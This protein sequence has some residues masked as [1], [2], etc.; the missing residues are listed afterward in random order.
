[1]SSSPFA[2]AKAVVAI[3]ESRTN[4][5]FFGKVSSSL[6][7]SGFFHLTSNLRNYQYQL[8]NP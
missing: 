4:S 5:M 6:S 8:E 3:T 1:M 2:L 7:E